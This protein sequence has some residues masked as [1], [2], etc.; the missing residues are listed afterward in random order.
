LK[1]DLYVVEIDV[2]SLGGVFAISFLWTIC[3][4]PKWRFNE[5][6]YEQS[7]ECKLVVEDMEDHRRQTGGSRWGTGM[8]THQ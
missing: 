6:K 2:T 4:M 5:S 3:G 7:P 8:A 1:G